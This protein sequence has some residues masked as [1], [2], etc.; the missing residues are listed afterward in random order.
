MATIT[1]IRNYVDVVGEIWQPGI[2]PCSYHYDLNSSA[3]RNIQDESGVITREGVE[4]WLGTHA[5]DFSHIIDFC[6]SITVDGIDYDFD[7]ATEEGALAYA[8]TIAEWEDEA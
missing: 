6:A 1:I 8:D 2:G 4:D 3:V 7:F 5:G